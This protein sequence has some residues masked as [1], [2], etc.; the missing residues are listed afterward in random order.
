[1]LIRVLVIPC[2]LN[3]IPASYFFEEPS[4]KCR[5]RANVVTST[6]SACPK[7]KI[8]LSGYSQGGYAVHNAANFLGS[9]MSKVSAVVVFGDPMSHSRVSNID[10]S[11]VKIICHQGDNICEQ[12]AIILP[13]HITYAIDAGSASSFVAS[14]L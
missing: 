2:K 7:T 11:R 6:L 9:T 14:K 4:N 1:M 5:L 12:G 8:V 13:Q 3:I 10:Q